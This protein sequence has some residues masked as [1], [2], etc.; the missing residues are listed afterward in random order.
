[1]HIVGI[2][3]ARM[4]ST[5]YPDKPMVP[6]L[7]MP[8]IGHVYYRSRMAKSLDDVWVATCDQSIVDYIESIG[9]N[10]VMTANSHE[11]A[12]ERIA[13]ALVSIEE[14]TGKRIDAAALLQGDE[15]MILPSMIDELIA[16]MRAPTPPAPVVNLISE[17]TTDEEFN[18]PNTVKVVM[19]RNRCAL[20]LSREAIPSNKKYSGA[21]PRWKQLG[22]IAFTRDALLDYVQL[23][24]TQLEIIESVD[25]NRL[26]EHG[27]KL[28]M[29]PTA[30]RTAAVDTP[31]DRE[32]VEALM[33]SDPLCR[34]YQA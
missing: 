25:M 24:P 21:L 30:H 7:G 34:E 29:I 16:P 32:R 8:M 22:M 10:A 15:P 6:I 3:A 26:V 20:Y 11:R 17:I 27:R 14:R 5:R 2:A 19:D 4:A 12:T 33:Q 28:C 9:G 23:E 18:D 13:E 1:M 31:A